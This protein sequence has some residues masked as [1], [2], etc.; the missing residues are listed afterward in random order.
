MKSKKV[1]VIGV[2]F[3]LSLFQSN[4]SYGAIS[5]PIVSKEG[6]GLGARLQQG[7]DA[8]T[9]SWNKVHFDFSFMYEG[10]VSTLKAFRL[11]EKSPGA[12]AFSQ[13]IEFSDLLAVT[14]SH[15]AVSG[16]WS[17]S[18]LNTTWIISKRN[19]SLLTTE[20][21]P[22][23]EPTSTYL[24]GTH[25]YYVT[26]VDSS[27]SESVPS[28][29]FNLNVLGPLQILDPVEDSTISLQPSFRW[30]V[31]LGWPD[32][33]PLYH[34]SIYDGMKVVWSKMLMNKTGE[35]N[36]DGPTLDP[37]QKYT[38]H[39]QGWWTSDAVKPL[40]TYFAGSNDVAFHV[41]ATPT[42]APVIVPP[43][44]T[45]VASPVPPPLPLVVPS[46][47]PTPAKVVPDVQKTT[48]PT[49]PVVQKI[50]PPTQG[51]KVEKEKEKREVQERTVEVSP[52]NQELPRGFIAQLWHI[53]FSFFFGK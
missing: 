9:G 27:G 8:V 40:Q 1:L 4:F 14:S 20:P 7:G 33:Q 43:S 3:L 35:L 47:Q 6:H 52:K 37:A 15:S 44:P 46:P 34:I 30:T 50:T 10:D 17:L 39:I 32:N 29:T 19:A 25:S 45:P 48:S 38:L 2:T 31:A 26:A 23:Y 51:Q 24:I 36:Y 5:A 49:K 22:L 12:S 53:V 13:L 28:Q 21:V 16:T 18:R 41:S 11:Y 42:P